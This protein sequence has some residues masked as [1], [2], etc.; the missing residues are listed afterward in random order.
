[1]AKNQVA[2]FFPDTVQM[3]T[4]CRLKIAYCYG[5][6]TWIIVQTLWTD[7]IKFQDPRTC[8]EGAMTPAWELHSQPICAVMPA[9]HEAAASVVSLISEEVEWAKYKPN[10]LVGVN[11]CDRHIIEAYV[12]MLF[13]CVRDGV[14]AKSLGL[15]AETVTV[16]PSHSSHVNHATNAVMVVLQA[17]SKTNPNVN[18]NLDLTIKV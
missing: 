13:A 11:R 15:R 10:K 4:N 18:S 7:A 9:T 1:M 16:R 17:Y 8:V 5:Q 2:P 12:V 3:R 14:A 6:W